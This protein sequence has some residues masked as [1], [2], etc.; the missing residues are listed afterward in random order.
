M[1]TTQVERSRAQQM[2]L[3]DLS[4]EVALDGNVTASLLLPQRNAAFDNVVATATRHQSM[5]DQ[6]ATVSQVATFQDL[7]ELSCSLQVQEV[8]S[9]PDEFLQRVLL[10]NIQDTDTFSNIQNTRCMI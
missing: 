7:R 8:F 1:P 6:P 4:E 2:I 3:G 10:V 9:S 5:P